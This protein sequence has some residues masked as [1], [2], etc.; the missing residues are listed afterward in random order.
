MPVKIPNALP[1][2]EILLKENIFVMDCDR[3]FH[4]D[5][6]PLKILLL[7]LMPV[8]HTTETQLLRHISNTPL[9]L[10]VTFLCVKS[11]V[12]KNT[13]ES[14]LNK[15]YSFFDDVKDKKFDGMIVT[16]APV[17]T[18]PFEDVTYWRELTEIFEWSKTRVTSVFHICW[19]AQAA[20]RYH[21]GVPKHTLDKKMFGVFK[22]DVIKRNVNLL[23][24]FDNVFY[25]PHSRH[26]EIRAEDISKIP[27]LDILCSS[28][29]AG[30]YIVLSKDGRQVFVTG[31]SEYDAG[32]LN[33]E[34]KRDLGKGLDIS[35]PKNYYT[36]D[37]PE[38]PPIVK[39]RS[40]ANL[41]YSNWLNYYVYQVTPYDINA[42]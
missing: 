37:D 9:Q 16:G 2:K 17:E 41:L 20:L 30:V 35:A 32:T 12:S 7:N 24:G 33:E 3:A 38:K 22:H 13:P 31:H 29:E 42:I 1:A 15:F 4:Q 21:Y 26:T 5:I 25:A 40:H 18:L 28:K 6:R 8:K 19:G 11:H 27:S 23:R 14:Y 34:Y 36:D 10:D 39:W